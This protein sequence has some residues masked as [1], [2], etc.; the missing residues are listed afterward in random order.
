MVLAAKKLLESG[1]ETANDPE[2]GKSSGDNS[3]NWAWLVKASRKKN[4]TSLGS[5]ANPNH[6]IES[7]GED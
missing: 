2:G 6:G 1:G 7:R 3:R 5:G 4:S